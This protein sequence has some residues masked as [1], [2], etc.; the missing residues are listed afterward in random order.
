VSD[1]G[2]ELASELGSGTNTT[3]A[4][5]PG[6]TVVNSGAGQPQIDGGGSAEGDRGSGSDSNGSSSSASTGTSFNQGGESQA[7][8]FRG[9]SRVVAGWSIVL[10]V[11]V[12]GMFT[13][14]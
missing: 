5:P 12:G 14:L 3:V 13:L 4:P 9:F 7:S 6:T 11:V 10:G 8:S 1:K 2:T